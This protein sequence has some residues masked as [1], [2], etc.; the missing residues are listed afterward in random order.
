MTGIT[1]QVNNVWLCALTLVLV[2]SVRLS[3]L[4]ESSLCDCMSWEIGEHGL[5]LY[6]NQDYARHR[7]FA[8]GDRSLLVTLHLS[9]T[10]IHTTSSDGWG[11]SVCGVDFLNMSLNLPRFSWNTQIQFSFQKIPSHWFPSIVLTEVLPSSSSSPSCHFSQP[12]CHCWQTAHFLV[13][14]HGTKQWWSSW[15]LAW[16]KH[17]SYVIEAHPHHGRGVILWH[18]GFL[19]ESTEQPSFLLKIYTMR[20]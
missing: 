11:H 20:S 8:E 18:F 2:V 1:I 5:Y 4:A 3:L 14:G 19:E 13:P 16:H 7:L 15:N 12:D 17:D 6:S 10:V 9:V